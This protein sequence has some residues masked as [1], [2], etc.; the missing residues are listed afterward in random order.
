[1]IA[2]PAIDIIDGSLVRLSEGDYSKVSHY[3]L[4]PLEAAKR[5]EDGGLEYLHLVDLDGAEGNGKRNLKV[6]EEIAKNVSMH[7]DFGGG[8][9]SEEDAER[10]FSAGAE[11]V[12]IGSMAVKRKDDVI[13]LGRKYPGR[14][15]I[16]SDVRNEKV[17]ISGWKEN[18]EL[19][20]Y[21]FPAGYLKEGI[22][23]ATV[24]DISRDG[25][26]SG[27]SNELYKKLLEKLP[28][29]SLIASGGVSS[30]SDLISLSEIGVYGAIVG[31]AY[32]EGR[33]SI[34][35]MKEAECSQRG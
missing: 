26:L 21:S 12:N 17:S 19:D 5:F 18:T 34:E 1:M 10:A 35:E 27:P 23:F 7:I 2:I 14:I 25:M 6:L 11:K 24:T 31:K 29:L 32:Y 20:V 28:D 22:T 33:I 15:I 4:T 8:I 9:R 13:A 3:G 30:E 16:S